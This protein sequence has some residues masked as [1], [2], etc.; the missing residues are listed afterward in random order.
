[1]SASEATLID[2][3]HA[4]NTPVDANDFD[5]EINVLDDEGFAVRK[6]IEFSKTVVNWS[7][8]LAP[9]D[10]GSDDDGDDEDLHFD[11]DELVASKGRVE[12][13]PEIVGGRVVRP[14]L[15]RTDDDEDDSE[16]DDDDD[17]EEQ[18]GYDPERRELV[19]MHQVTGAAFHELNKYVF[20]PENRPEVSV[21]ITYYALV[22]DKSGKEVRSPIFVHTF[23]G[24]FYVT[25]DLSGNRLIGGQ[26]QGP[27]LLTMRLETLAAKTFGNPA[28]QHR[29]AKLIQE[30]SVE[31]H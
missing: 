28:D 9:P 16:D 6:L 8:E 23:Y 2:A 26:R 12:A 27:L 17:D 30:T 13:Q 1:M 11:D 15:L 18:V 21:E 24:V 19:L 14:G 31:E 22:T 10:F 29:L 20:D 5:I 25:D 7:Y 4:H 3:L